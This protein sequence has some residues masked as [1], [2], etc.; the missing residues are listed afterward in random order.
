MTSVPHP[1]EKSEKELKQ[2][3]RECKR[4]EKWRDDLVK[5]SELGIKGHGISL[6]E[7][8]SAGKEGA[9]LRQLT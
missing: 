3:A 4:C 1:E 6:V 8:Q 7:Q 2:D 9:R 5:E